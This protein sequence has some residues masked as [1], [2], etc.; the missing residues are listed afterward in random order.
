[1][2]KKLVLLFALLTMLS[3]ALRA[4]IDTEFWFAP[5]D[6]AVTHSQV[7]IR[8]CFTTYDSAAVITVEQPNN[9]AFPTSTITVPADNFYVLD[10]SSWVDDIETKPINTV[11]DRG[12]YIHSTSSISCYYECE[13]V[14]SEIYTLKGRNSLGTY[15]VVPMQTTQYNS[16][17][18]TLYGN[19]IEIIATEDNTVVQITA[20]VALKGGIPPGSTITVTLNRGQ[21]YSIQANAGGASD[22]LYNTIIHSTKPIAVNSTD[23]SVEA[24][25][26]PWNGC[27][28]IGDQI[29]PVSYAGTK[30]VAIKNNSNYEY[31]YIFPVQ[32]NTTVVI[33]N[34]TTVL[35]QSGDHFA[36]QLV[37]TATLI[38]SDK[39][40]IVFQVTAI[41]SE[42]GGTMLPDFECTGSHVIKHL[43]PN[44]STST[45]TV[46]V[47]TAHT[48]NF[49]FNGSPNILTPADFNIVPG[50]SSLSY[51][52]KDINPYVPN[53]TMMT[54]RNDA[55]RFSLGIIEGAH[56]AGNSYGFFSDYA[57]SSYVRFEM[58]SLY[59][60]GDSIV[61]QYSAPNV[62]NL[63]LTGPNGVQLSTPPFLLTNADSTMS[64][65]YH[66]S[67]IDTASCLNVLSD[68]IYIR[69]FPVGND[70]THYT[71]V[72]CN[73]Y[74][75][76]GNTYTQSGNYTH[77]TVTS[78]GCVNMEMLHL[79]ILP[80][81]VLTH[82]PD[83]IIQPGDSVTLW[84]S[85][86]DVIY[87]TDANGNILST[88]SSLT[89]TPTTSTTY[90]VVGQNYTASLG[91]NLVVNGN[92]EQGNVGFISDLGYITGYNNMYWGSYTITT[93]GILIWGTDHLYGYGG[94]G[95]FM[96]VDG[97]E[98]PNAIVWQQT[99]P[100]TPNTYYAF[101]AQVAS[102]L[103]S[104]S[105]NSWA[106]LQFSVNGTQL[107]PIFHSPN[108]LN[109]WYPYYEVWYSG[110][111]TSATLTILNQNTNGA[112]N[113]FGL[114][115]IIFAPL[116]ECSVSEA[117]NVNV[118]YSPAFPD[119]VDSA[120]CTVASIGHDWGIELDW[121]SEEMVS[122]LVNPL[123]GDINGDHVPEIICF[124]PNN[125]YGFY[126]SN[127][128]L[129]FNSITHQI[130]HTFTTPGPISTVDAA[131]YGIIKLPNGHVIMVIA[132]QDHTMYAYDLTAMGTTSLWSV[133]TDYY[134]PNVSFVD[135]NSDHYPEIYIGNKIYDAETGA[136]L[137]SDPNIT[138][139]ASS[140]AHNGN[141]P[142]PS[143]CVADVV[144]DSRP[145][146]ILGN[147]IYEVVITNRNGLAGNSITLSK[148]I[149]PP[150]GIAVDGHSQV[151]DFNL[152]GHLD[153]LVSNK[154]SQ[155]GD[156][157]CY[158]WDVHNNTVSNPL[159]ISINDGGK[160][161][162]LI[163]D[164]DNDDTLEM[165][166]QCNASSGNKVKCY[167]YNIASSSFS[168]LWDI[169]VDED[170]YSNSMTVFD[171]N[172]DG[173]KDLLISDQTTVRIVNGSG[174]SHIT[175]NDTIPVYV[176]TSLSFGEC[177]V[178]QYPV[179]ADVDADGSAELVVL[180][181][182]GSGHTYQA[183]LNVFKSAS[184]PWAPARK[185]WNQYMYNVTNVNE[186]LSV[187]QYLFNN[188]TAFTDPQGV[189][190]RP[191]NNFL[192]QATTID[193]YGRPFYAVADVVL[194][195]LSQQI[196]NDSTVITLSLCNQGDIMLAAPYHITVYS[197][198]YGGTGIHTVEVNDNLPVDSCKTLSFSIANT[199]YCNLY[200]N[201]VVAVNDAGT[202][203]AQ[204]GGQQPECD[205][206]NNTSSLPVIIHAV[207]AELSVTSC[208]PYVWYGDILTQSGDYIY[209]TNSGT[210]CDSVITLHL[211]IP[212]VPN[213][214]HSP[215]TVIFPGTTAELWASGTDILSW[216]DATGAVISSNNG[217]ISVSPSQTS[218][219]Y[220]YG[221]NIE[222]ATGDN[223]V[224]NGDFEQG[225][226]GFTSAYN[227]SSNLWPEGNY[228]VGSNAHNYHT[229]FPSWYDHT[230][231]AG[232]YM[233]INGATLPNTNVWTQTIQI[234]PNTDYAFAAWVCSLTF[235]TQGGGLAQLQFSINGSQIGNVFSA[236]STTGWQRFYEVWN[237]GNNTTAT[238][239]ILN[240]N[241]GGDLNDFGLDDISFAPLSCPYNDS[242]VV[243]VAMLV[244]SAVCDNMFPFEWNGYTFTE[245][246]TASATIPAHNGLDSVVV[247]TVSLLTTS[248]T[249]LED[250]ICQNEAYSASGFHLSAE[251]TSTTGLNVFTLT[252]PNFLGCDSVVELNLTIIPMVIP[253]FFADPDKML[254]SESA[255]T[256][257]INITDTTNMG[258]WHYRWI[259]DFGDGISDT[260][261]AYHYEHEY[262]QMGEFEVTLTLETE[263]QC[264]NSFSYMVYV[265]DNLEYPNVITP[266]GD[267]VNDV[268]IIKNM[269]PNR[270]NRLIVYDRWGKKVYDRENYQT[271][272]K[273]DMLYNVSEGFGAENLSD[274]VY[275]YTF[276]YEGYSRIFNHHSSLTIIRNR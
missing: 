234:S 130:M 61:F 31:V 113:D 51:C 233:I 38:N 188:A 214:M 241:T 237:S 11:L 186:D 13:G 23:D 79:T 215:D 93:D 125:G 206:T 196:V 211:T 175:G 253:V 118:L 200:N 223:L 72:S 160:S 129:V 276:Y 161:I 67:G 25:G 47:G 26:V 227:Y 159:I 191:F 86:T 171:F 205:I 103:A 9:S 198:V 63:V 59:C 184:T 45:I 127:Q 43:R 94:S 168:F 57:R 28:L 169:Y 20:P 16:L 201:L 4:Q 122:P 146:L 225:N 91:N 40:V 92:F 39:P 62:E 99:V 76:H 245:P 166:I 170:S 220:I 119:N 97:T 27:D 44:V 192:Q 48:G 115:E 42:L 24:Y 258:Q 53:N 60:G 250:R 232:N 7:P 268:L 58:D 85:G 236:P 33:H 78:G 98:T 35:M 174:H 213:V 217:V 131:P 22:H 224:V 257:L 212:P 101:S 18:D 194:T 187:P 107:G 83:T 96:L 140:I 203:I 36:R 145:D 126:G 246:G 249:V 120:N 32:N 173:N 155:Y 222:G 239:T 102:T 132:L 74:T 255:L 275:Y 204:E 65:W 183:Y 197:D 193:Q 147:E 116:A 274:G 141:S 163:A 270:P 156:V 266:N 190:R 251:E 158:V 69:V 6:I 154:S 265:E 106:L 256:H 260:T 90:Y 70:T 114:D 267:G 89:V 12:F 111:N 182:F 30:Y 195:N 136:L 209:T 149:T 41:V 104:N 210:G 218:V 219:Y 87:W 148:S 138:N 208:E 81:P 238:I 108:V 199:D 88:T 259:W 64:G 3:G 121:A 152:D 242:V 151:A 80:L 100:V 162:P 110:N 112:G 164:V 273:D 269:N 244:D 14:N 216:S 10:V 49:L 8:F 2:E 128:V 221:Q 176:L 189:V 226:T 240:Q 207:E 262:T 271:Y 50:D 202:G 105:E 185:V 34:D 55:G 144:G 29:V 181:R 124:A 248:H 137:I 142:L 109:I 68:S 230:N 243:V 143:P 135:F 153:V 228:Y 264:E 165:V 133:S 134:A 231:G 19:K 235:G 46:V 123:V 150:A 272:M 5:P 247:M 71:V 17:G 82:S 167:K 261:L 254:L 179:V 21:S 117:V 77:E 52:V 54:I 56:G 66:L 178:M 229:N 95:Q 73:D 139:T 15:F 177:T 172:N 84:A 252:L 1:M 180:G 263:Q 37:N 75:W 157:G